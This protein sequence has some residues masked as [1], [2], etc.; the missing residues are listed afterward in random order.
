MTAEVVDILLAE[1]DYDL[2][3]A[4]ID[5]LELE[6]YSVKAVPNGLEALEWLLGTSAPPSL[7]FLDLMMPVMD[8]W[9]FRLEQL[10]R[11]AL[12]SIPVVVLSAN[13][14][15]P[16]DDGVL[17]LRKPARSKALLALV[18]RYCGPRGVKT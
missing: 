9:Q 11:P 1:D 2:R 3:E 5:V 12:A 7:I 16:V 15:I 14:E 17:R 10:A 18:A 6:G 4:M 13:E 8:G